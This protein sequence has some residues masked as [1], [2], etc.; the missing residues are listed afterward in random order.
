MRLH[1]YILLLASALMCTGAMAQ[2]TIDYDDIIAPA[3]KKP[4]SFE[5]YVVQLAWFNNASTQILDANV[6]IAG[7]EKQ[8]AK[9]S[10]MD[11]INA[12]VN[13][14]SQRDTFN[15]VNNRFT[16]P[17]FNYGLSVNAGG[18][19]NNKLRVR[20]ADQMKTIAEAEKN[21]DK[22]QFRAMVLDRLEQFDN[23]RE[24]LTIRRNAEI[25][26]ETNYTLVQS[27]YDQGKAQFEDLAQASEV[28]FR[29]VE[30]TSLAKSRVVRTRLGLEEVVGEPYEKLKEKREKMSVMKR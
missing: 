7:L 26:A 12:N 3:D 15:F 6:E 10:W 27:L 23:S 19:L 30:S 8:A 28:Y 1:F 14:N 24:L 20:L 13:F 9:R 11:Q 21:Q 17:G 22:L 16:G 18:L 4:K 2:A 25:D 29:A 5:E